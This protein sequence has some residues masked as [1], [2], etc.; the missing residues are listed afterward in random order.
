MRFDP[1]AAE[2]A[3]RRWATRGAPACLTVP[4]RVLGLRPSP[5][6]WLRSCNM[7]AVGERLVGVT[8]LPVM[9]DLRDRPCLVVGG[10]EVGLRKVEGLL[11]AGAAVTV[12]APVTVRRH[13]GAGRARP[14]ASRAPPLPGGRGGRLPSRLRRDRQRRSQPPGG[15]RR[16]GGGHLGQ[17]GGRA[18]AL[19]LPR[20]GAR[21]SRRVADRDR[22]ERRGAVRGPPPPP[23]PRAAPHRRV[24]RLDRRRGPLPH[25]RA[26]PEPR[27]GGRGGDLRPLLRRDRRRRRPFRAR[28]RPRGRGGMARERRRGG[29]PEPRS[30]RTAP[31]SSHSSAPDPATPGC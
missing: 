11:E 26:H 17:R 19:H 14:V 16:R 6:F 5:R 30:R 18:G 12:V 2:P 25:P 29:R 20:P 1:V 21:P 27:A 10:G 23:A 24:G 15:R 7:H 3:R 22:L 4:A 9:L 13:R 8:M 31:V 28:A